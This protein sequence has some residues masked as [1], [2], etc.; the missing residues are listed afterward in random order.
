[1]KKRCKTAD[2]EQAPVPR[3]LFGRAHAERKHDVA[4][5]I[6]LV[7]SAFF[8]IEPVLRHSRTYWMHQ[9]PLYAIFLALYVGYLHFERKVPRLLII[10]AAIFVLG[11]V[12]I[13]HNVGG[14]SFFIYVAA[15]LP[16]C[17]ESSGVLV[18]AMLIEII[19]LTD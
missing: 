13:P 4:S 12:A 19:A 3:D 1:M 7:Y 11:V 16:F 17:V 10:V 14:S 9:L 18:G 15:L 8:F 2:F 6:W 5:Y